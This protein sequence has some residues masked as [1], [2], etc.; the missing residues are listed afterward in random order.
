MKRSFFAQAPEG[1][2]FFLPPQ[3]NHCGRHAHMY[4]NLYTRFSSVRQRS[5]LYILT[6][7]HSLKRPSLNKDCGLALPR[8]NFEQPHTIPLTPSLPT[9]KLPYP[10]GLLILSHPYA[11][12]PTFLSRDAPGRDL[13]SA[14]YMAGGPR[15]VTFHSASCSPL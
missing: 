1:R 5:W 11:S 4:L 6:Y 14:T 9:G 7:R 12:H 10:F 2:V 3:Q 8:D 15:S 13:R